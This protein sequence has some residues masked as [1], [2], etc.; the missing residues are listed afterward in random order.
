[1]TNLHILPPAPTPTISDADFG[2]WLPHE[3]DKARIEAEAAIVKAHRAEL[4]RQDRELAD[5]LD[6]LRAQYRACEEAQEALDTAQAALG[7]ERAA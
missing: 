3:D 6:A 1:M 7:G 5:R 4:M 2:A